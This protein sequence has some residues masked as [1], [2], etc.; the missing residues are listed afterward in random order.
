MSE[1]DKRTHRKHGNRLFE[2]GEAGPCLRWVQEVVDLIA[3]ARGVGASVDVVPIQKRSR[4][5]CVA[6]GV[7]G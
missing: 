3:E 4:V 7:R 2:Y 6:N 1:I 5:L